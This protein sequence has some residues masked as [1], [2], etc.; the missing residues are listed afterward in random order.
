M[1]FALTRLSNPLGRK[2]YEGQAKKDS[3]TFYLSDF[4]NLDSS[5][6]ASRDQTSPRR[7]DGFPHT[8]RVFSERFERFGRFGPVHSVANK[9]KRE[10]E[11]DKVF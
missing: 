4:S 2:A 8:H 9:I 3:K 6:L 7:L 10:T 1:R 11:N 5:E